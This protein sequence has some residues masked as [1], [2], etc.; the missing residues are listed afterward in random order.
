MPNV[1]PSAPPVP[2]ALREPWQ[3]LLQFQAVTPVAG[4]PHEDAAA[5][6]LALAA[7][8][9]WS[10]QHPRGR[11]W[12]GPD[13]AAW[14][15]VVQALV[16]SAQ[17]LPLV[18]LQAGGRAGPLLHDVALRLRPGAVHEDEAQE[19]DMA[20]RWWEGAR[21]AGL[22]VETDFGEC[23]RALEWLALQQHLL[24]LAGSEPATADGHEKAALLAAVAK[25]ALRY[26]PLKPLL[27]LLPAQPGA[28]VGA[29]YTF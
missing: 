16:N 3:A 13:E 10:Q 24:L 14:A 18:A 27:R 15:R 25:V 6:A 4:L 29:G 5:Q 26:G 23:W 21:R 7:F 11:A 8:A 2:G 17:A 28:D 12:A 20:I 22:P 9:R 19:L 1:T